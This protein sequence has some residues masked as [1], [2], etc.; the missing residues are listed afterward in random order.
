MIKIL[1]D[2]IIEGAA[3]IGEKKIAEKK[4]KRLWNSKR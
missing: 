1:E 3:D 2:N 4:K